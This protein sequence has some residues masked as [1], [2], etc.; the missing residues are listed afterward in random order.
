[1]T[2][3][4]EMMLNLNSLTAELNDMAIDNREGI[5]SMISELNSTAVNLTDFS[6]S[7]ASTVQIFLIS[8]LQSKQVKAISENFS[9]TIRFMSLG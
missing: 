7:L 2:N 6:E 4:T 3:I 9:R 5:D 8:L 1:M